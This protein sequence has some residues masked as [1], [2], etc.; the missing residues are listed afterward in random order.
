VA[1]VLSVAIV[2]RDVELVFDGAEQGLL[3]QL[4]A[5]LANL[6]PG[7]LI[8]WNGSAF[9]LPFLA[10]RA[11]HH[12]LDLGL[13]ITFDP[14]IVLSR[15]PLRGHP[16]AYRARWHE[17]R[18]L[19]GYR[20]YRSEID[21]ESGQSCGLKPLARHFGL[22]VVEVERDHIHELDAAALRRYVTSDARLT[23]A[24]VARRWSSAVDAIDP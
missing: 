5:A 3:V 1:A 14:T 11:R 15:D 4:D 10:D 13:R 12:G 9:D 22:A 23:H 7:V 18:H 16:G 20:L 21:P 24:L 2:G 6:A 17:H 8:T 19:D